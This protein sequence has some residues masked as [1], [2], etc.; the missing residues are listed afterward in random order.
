M[1]H[2]H[3]FTLDSLYRRAQRPAKYLR[4]ASRTMSDNKDNT[5]VVLHPDKQPVGKRDAEL[6]VEPLSVRIPTAQALLKI[7]KTLC[8]KMMKEGDLERVRYRT[9]GRSVGISMRSI[10][11]V[12]EG[13]RITLSPPEP[14]PEPNPTS[15]APKGPNGR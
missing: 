12:A 10:R 9:K 4:G 2:I 13:R 15:L 3:E 5:P 8:F 7:G 1:D 14:R 6:V 11:A